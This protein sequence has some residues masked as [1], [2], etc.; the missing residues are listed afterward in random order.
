MEREL[1]KARMEVE[2][3][4]IEVQLNEDI[5]I[6]IKDHKLCMD[7]KDKALKRW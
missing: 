5:E 6:R 4:E 2:Q 7:Y 1:L 3:A